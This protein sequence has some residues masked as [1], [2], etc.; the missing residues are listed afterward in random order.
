V[1][2]VSPEAERRIYFLATLALA[3]WYLLDLVV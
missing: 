2:V 3:A 1:T